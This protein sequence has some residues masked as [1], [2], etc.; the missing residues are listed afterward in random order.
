MT[1]SQLSLQSVRI[2]LNL[3]IL[4]AGPPRAGPLAIAASGPVGGDPGF[5]PSGGQECSCPAPHGSTGTH[6]LQQGAMRSGGYSKGSRR[7]GP[8]VFAAGELGKRQG[9]NSLAHS[10]EAGHRPCVTPQLLSRS[11][12]PIAGHQAGVHRATRKC[13]STNTAITNKRVPSK[14]A[15]E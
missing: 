2:P 14:E 9:Q 10:A 12:A 13:L 15:A 8:L 5:R 1:C 11:G 7:A 3:I 6:R 4:S